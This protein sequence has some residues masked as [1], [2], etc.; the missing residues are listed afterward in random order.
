MTGDAP[1][2]RRPREDVEVEARAAL[3]DALGRALGGD[4]TALDSLWS[5]LPAHLATEVQ[6]HWCLARSRLA[7]ERRRP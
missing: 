6:W 7:D 5:A 3:V 1:T 4:R 2:P